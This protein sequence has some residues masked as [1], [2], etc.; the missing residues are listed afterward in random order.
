MPLPDLKS[1]LSRFKSGAEHTVAAAAG[2]G[3]SQSLEAYLGALTLTKHSIC[4]RLQP[5]VTSIGVA[6]LWRQHPSTWP[7]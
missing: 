5:W 3:E 2:E 1:M 7:F 6:S 4:P